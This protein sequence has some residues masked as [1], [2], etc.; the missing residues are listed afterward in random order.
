[1][2]LPDTPLFVLM[3]PRLYALHSQLI[4]LA[5]DTYHG[6][7]TEDEALLLQRVGR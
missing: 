3:D 4:L 5:T 7:R 6:L 1:M 2:I